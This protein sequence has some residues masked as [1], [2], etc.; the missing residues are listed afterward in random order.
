MSAFRLLQVLALL[1]AV[2]GPARADEADTA[3]PHENPPATETP[4]GPGCTAHEPLVV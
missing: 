3:Q 1:A 2:S 4:S